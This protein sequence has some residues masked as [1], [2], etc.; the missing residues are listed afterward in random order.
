[1]N[2]RAT[3]TLL[4]VMALLAP[5]GASRAEPATVA[6]TPQQVAPHS[7]FVQGRTGAASSEN[8]GYMSN[9][10]FV[11]TQDG[12]VVF[13]ALGSPPLGEALIAAIRKITTQPVKRVVVSHYHADHF[14][15]LQAFKAVG[16]EIW[17]HRAA[18][19]YLNSDI[20]ASRLAERR[21]TLF[22]W[23]D[24][25]TRLVPADL[26]LDGDTVFE[27]GGIHFLITHA[28]P[29]H[30]PEDLIMQVREDGVLFAGDL[31]FAGRVPFVGDAD[32][33]SWIAAIDKMLAA[34]PKLIVTG[35]GPASRAAETDLATTR[36]Y[37]AYLRKVMGAAVEDFVPFE[38]AY[39]RADWSRFSGLPAFA[40]AN[41]INAYGT[42]LLLERESLQ[43]K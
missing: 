32:S 24:E 22:P 5:P 25:K 29:A 18:L 13:D 38:E 33:K 35:H 1:M 3:R 28:G 10:G 41:R 12:V 43:K 42:Y 19:E 16:A 36:E 11:V 17:A 8:Q 34:R 14:Y 20:A 40:G 37:L 39:D 27:L 2:A 7:Y 21:Q 23:I 9:A 6:V 4:A 31:L 30:S 15:G 26:W